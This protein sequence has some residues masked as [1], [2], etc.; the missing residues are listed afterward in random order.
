ML[1][2]RALL[3]LYPRSFRAEYGAEMLA[4]FAREWH[5]AHGAARAAL[6]LRAAGDTAANAAGVHADILGQDLRYAVRSLRRTPGFTVTAILVS[7]LGIGATT[8]AFSVADH[9]LVRPLPFPDSDRLVRVWENQTERGY[10]RM[11]PSPP[12]FLDWQRQATSFERLE[13]WMNNDTASLVGSGEPL[14][15]TGARVRGGLFALLGRQKSVPRAG[16]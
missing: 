10:G 8:A 11:E 7:A 4:D 9:V 14:R 6:L 12:T 3:R 15:L 13:A 1:I 16:K 5:G 2:Y